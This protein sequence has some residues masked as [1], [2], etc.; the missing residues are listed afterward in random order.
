MP[1]DTHKIVYVRL[2]RVLMDLLLEVGLLN[3]KILRT[4]RH[5]VRKDFSSHIYA[6]KLPV[7]AFENHHG[8][9]YDHLK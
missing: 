6:H 8:M 7:E 3:I 9:R 2:K 5:N 4:E 1:N